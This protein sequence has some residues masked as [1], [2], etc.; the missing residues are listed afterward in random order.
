MKQL[1]DDV[2]QK[3]SKL[4]TQTYSTSFSLGIYCLNARFH[5]PIYAIYG[6]VRLADEI[7]DS[8]H[9]YNKFQ[10]LE[11]FE[12]ETYLSI[13]RKISMNPVLNSFQETVHKFNIP[14]ALI[15]S[16]LLSMKQD[17]T[18]TNHDVASYDSYIYGSAEVVGLMCLKVFT[19]N[20]EAL[21]DKLRPR[22][23]KLGAAFQKVNF[24]RDMKS[25][26]DFLGRVYFPGIDLNNIST[27][28]KLS[29]EKDIQADFEEALQGIKGLP[30][31]TRFGVYVAYIYYRNLFAR[32]KSLPGERILTERIR[33]PNYKKI[34]LLLSSYFKYSL[35]LL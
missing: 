2:S 24:L 11:E 6:F 28:D 12:R 22:A 7:V 23:R 3:T 4:V 16:F 10:L 35:N 15:D 21:Y 20:D 33:I 9:N 5:T 31:G 27:A 25:D 19:Q 30:K 18:R 14:T 17:L 34:L 8:M 26:N 32:I 1:F 13:D 29:I